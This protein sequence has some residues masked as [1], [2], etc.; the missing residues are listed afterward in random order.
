[1]RFIFICFSLILSRDARISGRIFSFLL[2]FSFD[3][4]LKHHF[5]FIYG[6]LLFMHDLCMFIHSLHVPA[7]FLAPCIQMRYPLEINWKYGTLLQLSLPFLLCE[8]RFQQVIDSPKVLQPLS[9]SWYFEKHLEVF[10]TLLS[11]RMSI[12]NSKN[13]AKEFFLFSFSSPK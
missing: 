6:L 10:Q 5:S 13:L 3:Q 9:G 8:R 4:E 11:N 7:D 1:M 2:C 12:Q